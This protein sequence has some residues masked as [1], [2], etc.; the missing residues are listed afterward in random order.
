MY[1]DAN[2]TFFYNL[3]FSVRYVLLFQ[4]CFYTTD[5]LEYKLIFGHYFTFWGN[6]CSLY[7]LVHLILFSIWHTS[8][9]YQKMKFMS[10][11][12]FSTKIG[13]DWRTIL[14]PPFSYSSYSYYSYFVYMAFAYEWVITRSN[15]CSVPLLITLFFIT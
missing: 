3:K 12:W 7:L 10:F 2:I 8:A 5:N 4:I 15:K 14:A 6:H 13:S 1:L 11:Y 9:L